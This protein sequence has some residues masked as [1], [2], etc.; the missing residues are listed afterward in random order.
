VVH[1]DPGWHPGLR[2]LETHGPCR[3]C[4]FNRKNVSSYVDVYQSAAARSLVGTRSANS[5]QR[6]ELG[7]KK[8]LTGF[9]ELP[10][11]NPQLDWM[12]D[13]LHM[14]VKYLWTATI[15]DSEVKKDLE[16]LALLQETNNDD[17][18]HCLN[19]ERSEIILLRSPKC[20]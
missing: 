17:F 7:M 12:Y 8:S 19:S 16:A 10:G 15:D 18:A 6:E 1:G 4:L 9:Y 5:A 20:P 13:V 2:L 14:S 3:V 11:V